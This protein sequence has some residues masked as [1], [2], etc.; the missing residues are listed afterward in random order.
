MTVKIDPSFESSLDQI[1]YQDSN[2]NWRAGPDNNKGQPTGSFISSE[3]A[4]RARSMRK[5]HNDTKRVMRGQK[6]DQNKARKLVNE[7]RE[8][9]KQFRSGEMGE[10]EFTEW[11][12]ENIGSP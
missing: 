6:V 5:Y 12:N 10:D 4:N 3:Y 11:I 9:Q 1:A 8:K 2:G 7:Y